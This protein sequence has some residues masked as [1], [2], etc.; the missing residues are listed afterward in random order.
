MPTK[1]T[2]MIRSAA[3]SPVEPPLLPP[4]EYEYDDEEDDD[5]SYEYDGLELELVDEKSPPPML[6]PVSLARA[7]AA[8]AQDT[9]RAAQATPPRSLI[10]R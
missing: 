7:G 2:A 6:P 3:G 9:T 10:G 5:E 4:P 8:S 1:I